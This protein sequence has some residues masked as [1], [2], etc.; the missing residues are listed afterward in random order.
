MM[1]EARES[2]V[3]IECVGMDAILIAQE[4][5]FLVIMNDPNAPFFGLLSRP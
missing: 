3:G 4:G 2:E 1:V 5:G